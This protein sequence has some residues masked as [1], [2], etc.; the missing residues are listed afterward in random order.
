MSLVRAL[1]KRRISSRQNKINID[2]AVDRFK[3]KEV[4][5]LPNAP[6]NE[7]DDP[8]TSKGP[9]ACVRLNNDTIA[10]ANEDGYINLVR[11]RKLENIV[12]W[13]AHE[14][15][16]FDI[17]ADPDQNRLV[18]ASG[19]ATVRIWDVSQKKE[20]V[21]FAPHF[22]TIKSVSIYDRNIIASGSRDGTIKIHDI[23]LKDPTIIVI[24]DAHRNLILRKTAPKSST[25]TDPISCVTNVAFDPHYPRI[26][27][28]GANDA[29]IKLWDL[30]KHKEENRPKRTREGLLLLH[31][32]YHE[33]HHP[34]K[35]V[36]CG[37]AH[38][39]L[40]SGRVY[41]ACSDNKI[42]CYDQF[43]S[44]DQPTTKFTGFRYDNCSRL[45]VMDDR[46]LFSG[47]KGGGTMM[48]SLGERGSSLYYPETTKQPIGELKPDITDRYDT[49]AIETHWET[50]SVISFRDD[51]L[52]C[53][54]TMQHVAEKERKKLLET[55]DLVSVNDDISIQM[56]DIIGVNVLRQNIRLS[57]PPMPQP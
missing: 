33:V 2:F 42:Y 4:F 16:I 1:R 24:R 27:S 35:G 3:L 53:K 47:S 7:I 39:L 32:P 25:K 6:T 50:L 22:S 43:S 54:W 41:A 29:T 19:D 20:V 48:W 34:S 55:D 30:R 23:R 12:H 15:A 26:Y 17:K 14:N 45:A 51:G 18:T 56:S 38:L 44:C 28:A 10:V 9:L 11:V 52:V 49:N 13:M 36:H 21:K 5:R 40:S 37:Y 8:N 57:N 46:F 31:Q